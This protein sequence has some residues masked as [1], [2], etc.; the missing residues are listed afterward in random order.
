M[1]INKLIAVRIHVD[2]YNNFKKKQERMNNLLCNMGYTKR[3]IP[4]TKVIGLASKNKVYANDE[5]LLKMARKV[6]VR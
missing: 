3:H 6:K 5:D 2:D 1:S 4:L